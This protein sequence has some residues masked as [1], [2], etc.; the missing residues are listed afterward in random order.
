MKDY[1]EGA[2]AR[3][4]GGKVL[5][6]DTWRGIY[7][8]SRLAVKVIKECR[9]HHTGN[10]MIEA[11]P[12]ASAMEPHIRNE[13]FRRNQSLKIQWLDFEDDDHLRKARIKQL[14]PTMRAGR[15]A[16]STDCT[17]LRELRTQFLQFELV[18]DNGIL[19]CVSRLAAKIPVSLL[20]TEIAEEEIELARRRREDQ[21]SAMVFGQ[22]GR[23]QM[24]A[25]QRQAAA[26]AWNRVNALGLPDILGGLDG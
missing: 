23:E 26:M 6:I 5:V 10:L 16:I 12:G 11:T 15:I 13:G 25:Q 19:D 1:A 18:A 9:K 17:R 7:T 21:L 20:R 2:A 8:P 22:Q 14:E 4:Y 3:V 24:E